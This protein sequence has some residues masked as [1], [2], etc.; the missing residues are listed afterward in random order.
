MNQFILKRCM[1]VL[2]SGLLLIIAAPLLAL[3]AIAI[4]LTSKGPALFRQM[5]AGKD[6]A[7]FS[8]LKFR[9]MMQNAPDLRNADNSTFN[10][11]NDPRVTKIGHILRKTSCDELPQLIN[12]LRG[13]MSIVGPRPDLPD[14]VS[15]YR[16]EDRQRLLVKPGITGWAQIHG[17]NNLSVERRRELDIEYVRKH[18]LRMD[19]RIILHTIPMVLLG[20]GVYIERSVKRS[21]GSV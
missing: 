16:I 17:R 6:G 19:M 12:V 15:T 3:I 7:C 21:G 2:V 8:I 9:T 10:S 4:R 18:T 1:D 11:N 20:R 13:E 14:Q 5:R